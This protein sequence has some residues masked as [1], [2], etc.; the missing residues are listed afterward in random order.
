MVVAYGHILPK[1]VI[2]LPR[3]GTLNIHASLLPALRGAAPIQAAIRDGLAETGVTIMRMVPA[4]DAGP[5]AAPGAHADPR[6]RDRR[7]AR[8][9]ADRARRA[10]ADRG[11]G[12][13]RARAGE[14]AS[15]RTTPSATYATKL[16]RE[17]ARVD[18]TAS[19]HDVGR[20]IRAY[21]PKP[22]AWATLRGAEVKL[23]GARV[24]PRGTTHAAGRGARDR[25]GRDARGVRRRRRA[26]RGRAAVGEAAAQPRGVGPRPRRGRRRP[27]R[28]RSARFPVGGACSSLP[29]NS[30]PAPAQAPTLPVV[31]AVT[32]DEIVAARRLHRR[33]LRGDGRARRARRA[34]PA[35]RPRHARRGCRRWPRDSRRR[36]RSPARGSSSTTASTSRSPRARAARS[37]RAARS[38]SPMRA[39]PRRPSRSARACTRSRKGA[40]R[41]ARARTGSWPAT[42]SRRTTHPGEQERGLPFVRALGGG[43]DDPRRRDRRRDVRSTVACCATRV[44]TGSP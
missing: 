1:A 26:D 44:R 4:L 11:A 17:S 12:A 7:R 16:T 13:D 9:A 19:A 32:S 18:W 37:S 33:R 15:R 42:C 25:R 35:R 14:A 21:D 5:I 39:A 27:V 28:H 36:R 31:H 10:G 24:A 23:F 6:R 38:A 29:S 43:R 20:H 40:P 3:L 41:R 8:A 34:A 30:L 22:G 2:D